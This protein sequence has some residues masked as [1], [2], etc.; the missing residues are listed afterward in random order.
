VFQVDSFPSPA[1]N[2]AGLARPLAV[3]A[4]AGALLAGCGRPAGAPAA[5]ASADA[6]L[7][8]REAA[9]VISMPVVRREMLRVLETTSVV[10]SEHEIDVIPRMAGQVLELAVEENDTVESGEVLLQLEDSEQQLALREAEIALEEAAQAVETSTLAVAEARSRIASG[11]RAFEQAERDYQRDLA[12]RTGGENAYGSVSE[13][14]VE[15]SRLARDQAEQDLAQ[16]R[17]ALE[18][19]EA[20]ARSAETA[21]TRA[22]VARDR[23]A[24]TLER[25]R[26]RAPIAG[27]VAE[28]MARVG[29]QVSTGA[30]VFRL[31]DLEALRTVFYRPQRE[32]A[33]FTAADEGRSLE[34]EASAEAVPGARFRGRID[35]VSPTIDAASGSFRL[36]ASLERH[37]IDGPSDASLAPGMLVRIRIVTDRR[38]EALAV[39]KRAVRREGEQAFLQRVSEGRIERVEVVE[40][41][42]DEELVEVLPVGGASLAEG[43]RVVIVGG[44]D[45]EDGAAVVDT[46]SP[47][48]AEAAP[49]DAGPSDAG[50]SDAGPSDAG[51]SDAGPSDRPDA[52]ETEQP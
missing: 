8:P 20:E 42:G 1:A 4:V 3:A 43:E 40:G 51:P 25:M 38:P 21:V 39:P 27:Q 49:S 9:R 30:P 23:A 18:R 50:P 36:T 41:Y 19:A 15:A 5:E 22:R 17:L 2:R 33:L 24:L 7:R 47:A 44:R 26:I 28:R 29:D 46:A 13:R 10:E 12:L 37:P 31:T 16:F 6:G 48:A 32:L 14:T 35:R 45:L 11:E 34:L 52:A